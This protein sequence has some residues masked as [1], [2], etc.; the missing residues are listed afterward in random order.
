[1]L[2]SERSWI[3]I[4]SLA[5]FGALCG[6]LLVRPA[7]GAF[8]FW[9]LVL[10]VVPLIFFLAPG[11]WRNLCPVAAANQIPRRLGSTPAIPAPPWLAKRGDT[12]AVVLLIVGV[13]ARQSFLEENGRLLGVVL[14]GVAG[15]ALAGGFAFPG[16]SGWCTTVCPLAPVE[17]FYGQMPL[18]RVSNIH[19]RPCIG[20]TTGC[21][22]VALKVAG[23]RRSGRVALRRPGQV[24]FAGAFP[25]LVVTYFGWAP[26]AGASTAEIAVRFAA[27]MLGGAAGSVVLRAAFGV[28]ARSLSRV[29]AVLTLIA[30]YCYVG[31]GFIRALNQA[32]TALFR[33]QHEALRGPAVAIGLA[34]LLGGLAVATWR[35]TSFAASPPACAGRHDWRHADQRCPCASVH[36]AR[37]GRAAS[38]PR[39]VPG[40]VGAAVVVSQS[41]HSRL[42]A[43]GAGPA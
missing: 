30:F 35:P 25:A 11:W 17:R 40:V 18:A 38:V 20:C 13:A 22:D 6:L 16:K 32:G 15:L 8:V 9:Q 26:Q 39:G 4:A 37:S 24:L 23:A 27:V 12:V 2:N 3:S 10:P 29:S 1:V 33:L 28:S 14:L 36:V 31:P 7:A 42:N 5:A 21:Y 34:L 41:V 43:R 19:C